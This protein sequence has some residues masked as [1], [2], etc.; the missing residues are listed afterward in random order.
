MAQYDCRQVFDLPAIKLEVTEHQAEVK[1]CPQCGSTNRGEFPTQVTNIV[2]Y[3]EVIKAFIVYLMNYQ[4]IPYRRTSEALTD[5]TG[6]SI[7]EGTLHQMIVEGAANL[8]DSCEQI[9]NAIKKAGV[10]NFD[11]TGLYVAG[12]RLWLHV[13]A[14]P[15]LTYYDY[16]EKRGRQALD[17]IDIL[18]NFTGT[19]VHDGYSSYTDYACQ[20][21]LCNA[22]HLRELTFLSEQYGLSWADKMID[23]LL[24]IKKAVDEARQ[25]GMDTLDR[26]LITKFERRYQRILAE[27]FAADR[28]PKP[29]GKMQRG[30]KKQSKAKNLLDRLSNYRKETLAFMYDFCVPFDNNLAERDI[31][32]MK[33]QQKI[34]GCFRSLGGAKL[35]CNI[36]S[37]I[38]SMRK[39]GHNV[40][41]VLKSVFSANPIQPAF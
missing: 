35:F 30:R 23:H 4:L 6:Q 27:G 38:S 26:V 21:A 7:S 8:G 36:R 5:L 11:E 17:A 10:G 40:F 25:L 18:P 15:S 34:S 19:A 1:H 9:K 13:A 12:N 16:H 33:V 31:R 32:M 2:Q 39:Q 3:G 14:T 24:N 37:Y 29:V 20:H 28:P 22:H 41:T